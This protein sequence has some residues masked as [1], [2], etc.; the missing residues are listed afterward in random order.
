MNL[1]LHKPSKLISAEIN[2][3]GSKSISNRVLIIKALS[4]LD[5]T[6][7]N[8]SDSD[9][10]QHLNKALE[11]HSTSSLIDVGHAGTDMRFLTAFLSLQKGNYE[12]TGSD[13][14]QQRPVKDLVDV[15]VGLGA[16][17]IYN[18]EEGFPPLMIKGK[19]LEG[20]FAEINGN[21]SSQ[22]I[23]ALLL[24]APY[25]KNGLVLTIQ[26]ELVSKS[27]VTMTIAIM[28]E[29]GANV[30]WSG[31]KITVAPQQYAYDKK[32]YLVESDW[33]AAS[34]YYSLIALSPINTRITLNGLF[35]NSVQGD[36]VCE[37]NYQ[38]FGVN[39][40]Y[41]DLK[42]ILTKSD[43]PNPKSVL[44]YNFL[45]CPDVAQTLV[46]TCIGLKFSFYF[47][48]LQTLKVKETDRIIALKNEIQKMGID[49]EVTNHSIKWTNTSSLNLTNAISISTYKDH[50]MAMSFAPLCLVLNNLKI[51]DA[52]VVTKS[53][54]LFWKHLK[55]MGI[56]SIELS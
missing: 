48:G 6:I 35:R 21:V 24:V 27:Y 47:T 9:D 16:D 53:Y 7:Q 26:G 31:S 36:A 1:E 52:E 39:T 11:N 20:G 12:L 37:T 42:I 13:R 8:L 18:K 40:K 14:L 33:S 56:N 49:I 29:F 10:T 50:R 41:S 46:C 38:W 17:I 43:S 30:S 55:K 3:P 51:E 15:L 44:E 22:F 54:P 5:F 23:T 19:S 2:L 45:E 25:F 34:Y 32:Q 4:N 28:K